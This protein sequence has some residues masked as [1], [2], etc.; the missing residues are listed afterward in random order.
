MNKADYQGI[1]SRVHIPSTLRIVNEFLLARQNFLT[2]KLI[3][4]L[5]SL[6]LRSNLIFKLTNPANFLPD[7]HLD[8]RLIFIQIFH[9]S[10]SILFF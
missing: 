8:L 10:L 9:L 6:P 2:E 7:V 5:A 3:K 1:A 4:H